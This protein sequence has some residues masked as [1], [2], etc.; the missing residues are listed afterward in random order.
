M[1]V[2]TYFE[3][4]PGFN[5]E[6]TIRLWEAT[7]NKF[8][9]RPTVLGYEHFRA[10]PLS[11][12]LDCA[13][14]KFP[15]VNPTEYERACFRRWIALAYVGGGLMTDYDVMCNGFSYTNLPDAT[16]PVTIFD[17]HTPCAVFGSEDAF[18]KTAFAFI[19]YYPTAE[20][21]FNGKSHVSDQGILSHRK[22]PFTELNLCKEYG[23]TGWESS[24][25][26][27]FRNDS[28]P[29][30]KERHDVIRLTLAKLGIWE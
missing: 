10:H 2:H 22:V 20:D 12:L 25:L 1:K 21:N 18:L 5:D 24:P 8:G 14:S 9:W 26:I 17:G 13:V 23:K 29:K 27:H 7:W 28:I 6:Q 19:A 4:I 30:G 15:T 11:D 3:N 16:S